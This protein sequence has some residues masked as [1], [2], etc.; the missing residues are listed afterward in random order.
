[1]VSFKEYAS[2]LDLPNS[3][4]QLIG[5]KYFWNLNLLIDLE[6][7]KS[8]GTDT[9]WEI[10]SICVFDHEELVG[11]V[12]MFIKHHSYGEYVFDWSWAEAHQRL[13]LSYFPKLFIGIPFSPVNANKLIVKNIEYRD[14]AIE[15]IEKLMVN[16]NLSSIHYVFSRY[17]KE[18]NDFFKNRG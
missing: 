4:D 10:K 2:F 16:E 18:L 17:D 5:D 1:M 9:G 13:G 3:V 15:Y 7:S 12:P 14:L 6:V 8:I 11:F